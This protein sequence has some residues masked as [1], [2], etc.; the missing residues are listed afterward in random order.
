M[1][2]LAVMTLTALVIAACGGDDTGE[3]PKPTVPEGTTGGVILEI[4]DEGGFVPLEFNLQR[5]PRFTVFSDGTVITPSREQFTFP[6]PAVPQL[7]QHQLDDSTVADLLAFVDDLD[8]A[9]TDVLDLNNAPNVADASTTVVRYYDEAGEHR[10]SVYALGF[11]GPGA[12]AR[13]AI[14]E[15]MIATLADATPG[16]GD[17]YRPERLAVF[18]QEAG[19]LGLEQSRDGGAWP[20]NTTPDDLPIADDVHSLAC[21]TV[22]NEEAEAALS[23]LGAADSVTTWDFEGVEYRLLARP[24]LPHQDGC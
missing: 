19:F 11:D 23:A 4:S 3:E 20:L 10:L 21:F 6:G 8:L 17:D 16:P 7:V 2:I 24:L 13:F 1:R 22:E 18:V 9:A 14:L 12:D 15:S 5:V